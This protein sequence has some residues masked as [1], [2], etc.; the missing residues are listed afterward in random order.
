MKTDRTAK[1]RIIQKSYIRLSLVNMAV[2]MITN[3]CGFINN[4]VISRFLGTQELAAVGFFSPVAVLAGLVYV[5][6]LGTV[7]V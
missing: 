5:I 1:L 7:V 2:L 3:V 4:I 6:I